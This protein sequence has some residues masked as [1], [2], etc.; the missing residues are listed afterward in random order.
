MDLATR[1]DLRALNMNNRTAI[2]VDIDEVLAQHNLR[3]AEWHNKM[4]GTNYTLDSFI[5][6]N[7]Q[8]VWGIPYDEAEERVKAF[9]DSEMHKELEPVAGAK[10]ALE[11]LK[12]KHDLVVITV[13]RKS[14]VDI[15][16]AWLDEHFPDLFTSINFIHFW[17]EADKTTKAELCQKLGATHLIDDSLKNCTQAAERG[18]KALLFGDYAWNRADTLPNG[19]QRFKSWDEIK[20]FEFS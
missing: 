19:V 20:G 16:H 15:T 12:Q 5:S 4:Y 7:L 14:I 6:D 13:R 2:A 1:L 11:Y 9:H 8:D 3:L 18:V 10:E 17:D